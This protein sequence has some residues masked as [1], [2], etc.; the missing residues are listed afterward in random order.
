[1]NAPKE[2]SDHND[3]EAIRHRAY[4]IWLAEGRPHDRAHDHWHQ[5]V[6]ETKQL[7]E[8]TETPTVVKDQAAAQTGRKPR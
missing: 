7:A 4:M 6:A 8:Q 2:T 5:A 3:E 1:M